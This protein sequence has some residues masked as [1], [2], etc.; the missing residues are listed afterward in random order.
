MTAN[1]LSKPINRRKDVLQTTTVREFDGGWD[2]I[3]NELNLSSRFARFL[4]NF[5]RGKD[6]SNQVRPGTKLFAS[7]S[8]HM[9]YVV[10]LHY[11]GTSII[12]VGSNG[13]I[14]AIDGQ[15]TV[16]LIWSTAL[17]GA[18]TGN[19]AGWGAIEFVSF[20]EFNSDLILANG[21]DKPLI[22]NNKLIVGYL[23]DLA[24][25][26]N[27]NVPV[28]R[29][30][31]TAGRFLLMCG[32]PLEPD[33]LHI[34]NIDTSG[35]WFGDPAPN[36]GTFIDL[37]S[38]V[39]GDTTIKGAANF[40][41]GIVVAF[42]NS[43]LPGTLNVRDSSDNHTPTFDD[44]ILQ[45]G[46]VAHKT[47]VSLG[48][49]LL[50]LDDVGVPSLARALFTG[51]LRPERFSQLVDPEIQT[52]LKKIKTEQ[53]LEDYV[54]AVYHLEEGQYIVFIPVET[55]RSSRIETRMFVHSRIRSLKINSWQ[56]YRG[57]N[58]SAAARSS[59]NR[60]FLADGTNVMVLGDDQDRV[61]KDY[62]GIMEMWDDETPWSDQTGWSPVADANDS[63]VP[64]KF[65]W[66]LP[67]ADFDARGNIK[68]SQSISFDTIGSAAFTAKMFVDRLYLDKTDPGETW[69]DGTIWSDD[70]GWLTEDQLLTP[71]LE[72]DFVGGDADGLGLGAFGSGPFGGGRPSGDER[73]Y[74]WPSEFRLAKLR[75][76][77]DADAE[78][79][80]VAITLAYTLGAIG[81]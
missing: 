22:I 57:L 78:L 15:G 71:A 11:Y 27:A 31:V 45:H 8:D 42:R 7:V 74:D 30:V 67:W 26:S 29:Y 13:Q 41:D 60:V 18:L 68:T 66:E 23:A 43:L 75:F 79:S 81:R 59:L 35:T 56:E 3:D 2:V 25:G 34:S 21:I 55:N 37:G 38:R 36:D 6:G 70:L 16:T 63:G 64:I 50:M 9:S 1:P 72:M 46:T 48:E 47:M 76:E 77:G 17:A 40:R 62:E 54:H 19:P 69:A 73:P 4:R 44:E 51:S 10:G 5:K 20:A 52:S 14:V 32:D 49:D 12:A 33:R 24:T 39:T 80:F 58:I 28:A 53:A 65:V 61:F